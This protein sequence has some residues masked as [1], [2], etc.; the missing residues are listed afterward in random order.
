MRCIDERVAAQLFPNGNPSAPS[1]GVRFPEA[2]YR[3]VENA[4]CASNGTD[5]QWSTSFYQCLDTCSN[6]TENVTLP[7]NGRSLC[8]CLDSPDTCSWCQ[9]SRNFTDPTGDS[10]TASMGR[11]MQNSIADKCTGDISCGGYNGNLIRVRPTDCNSTSISANVID[12]S[13]LVTDAQIAS[14]IKQVSDGTFNALAFQQI[15]N[16]LNINNIMIRDI[17]PPCTDGTNGKISFTYDNYDGLTNDQIVEYLIQ[18]LCN[19]FN[20][21]R[22]QITIQILISSS[23]EKR[24][25]GS[26][27]T[28]LAIT[29]ISAF[30]GTSTGPAPAANTN[31]APYV[32]QQPASNDTDTD[33]NPAADTTNPAPYIDQQPASNDTDSDGNHVPGL[34]PPPTSDENATPPPTDSAGAHISPLW[35]L[36]M[37]LVFYWM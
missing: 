30:N 34:M 15:L 27:S 22:V 18:A 5:C 20:L 3:C 9:F 14:I 21:N 31:P 16:Q 17:S 25:L 33:G 24:Q 35:F 8:G 12:P 36:S 29:E 6:P 32:D 1:D 26:P 10:Y 28:S 11:C 23:T 19:N 37:F 4:V 7:C 2:C 13:T